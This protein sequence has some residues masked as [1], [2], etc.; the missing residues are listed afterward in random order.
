MTCCFDGIRVDWSEIRTVGI[1]EYPIYLLF[2]KILIAPYCLLAFFNS[3]F[4]LFFKIT[5]GGIYFVLI[6]VLFKIKVSLS[7]GFLFFFFT[8]FTFSFCL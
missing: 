7:P 3:F 1:A 2:Y 5:C 4:Y 6:S 8:I